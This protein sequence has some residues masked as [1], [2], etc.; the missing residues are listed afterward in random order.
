[1]AVAH[2][3]TVDSLHR[4]YGSSPAAHATG[5]RVADYYVNPRSTDMRLE[6][7]EDDLKIEICPDCQGARLMIRTTRSAHA[8]V[9]EEVPCEACG[10]RG[11]KLT[12]AGAKLF[13]FIRQ[14][15]RYH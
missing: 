4:C 9:T 2:L 11:V 7:T 5:G 14:A 3:V 1:M 6:F 15:G 10:G 8:I 13:D 12:Y